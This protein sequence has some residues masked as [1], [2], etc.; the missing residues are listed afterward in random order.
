[1]ES[2]PGPQP[3]DLEALNALYARWAGKMPRFAHGLPR[4]GS[5]RR[6]YRLGDGDRTA[7]GVYS[8]DIAENRA[9]LSFSLH[10]Q[11]KGIPVPRIYASN[12]DCT[13]Y[14]QQDLGD[15]SLL[16]HLE[17]ARGGGHGFPASAVL[18]YR[19]SLEALARMQIVGGQGLDYSLCTSRPDFDVQSMR[20]D[21]NYFKYYFLRA[22]K[23]PHDEQGL[24]DDFARLSAWLVQADCSHFMFRDFQARNIMLVDDR[25]YFID[26]QGGRR[27]AL[28]YDVAS[29]LY[30]AKADLP[31]DLRASLLDH[32]IL[33]AGEYATVDPVAF[34][35]HYRG[36]VLLRTLQVLG[37]YGFRGFFE[38]RPH[39][40]DSVPYVLGN[41]Q[42][43]L[44]TADLPVALP[45]LWQVLRQALR[46]DLL[47]F[48]EAKPAALQPLTLR[49]R[50]FSYKSGI[51]A[52][53]TA[54]GGG[55]VFDCRSVDNPGRQEEFKV[56]TG[57]DRAVVAYLDTRPEAHAFY[58]AASALVE[59]AVRNFL[60]RG[61]TDMMV[62]FGCT[63]GQ[64]RSVYFAEKLARE[65][66]S[67]FP[68]TIDLVHVEQEKKRWKN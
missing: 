14:L 22:I 52:D 40:L 55:F 63:G 37:S 1:M 31:E 13:A 36:Y 65:M 60:R 51:P 48:L 35:A 9:F 39:F 41:V 44:E 21:L 33:A 58:Q 45:T 64:H 5:D 30:Q 12:E 61:F 46:S 10:F 34:K 20:W 4:A 15:T 66:G 43:L 32:Y 28:Q 62:C 3:S 49:V 6:Y 56:L 8:G 59:A 23:V 29:L 26:Y 17:A 11:A 38:R 7:I 2:S 25:P 16:Q 47:G 19:Q 57:R 42:H 27:G 67:R 18:L 24:E 50:S 68:V 53:S 54:H